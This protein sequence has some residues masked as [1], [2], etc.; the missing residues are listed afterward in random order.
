MDVMHAVGNFIFAMVFYESFYKVLFRFKRR[1][2]VEYV[3]SDKLN[4]QLGGF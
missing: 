4:E 1:M 2:K 3:S